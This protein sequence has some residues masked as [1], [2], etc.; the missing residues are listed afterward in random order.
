[1]IPTI[2]RVEVKDNYCLEVRFRRP[3]D[4]KIVDLKPYL[5]KG[6]FKELQD[7]NYFRKVRVIFGGIEWPH[8]QDLS[9]ETLYARGHSI[10]RPTQR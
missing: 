4:T 8:K 6:I 5:D 2:D 7:E 1:M 9:A 3:S 10:K